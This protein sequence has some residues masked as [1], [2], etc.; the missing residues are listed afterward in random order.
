MPEGKNNFLSRELPV[1]NR[2]LV[3]PQGSEMEYA[4][5]EDWLILEEYEEGK[6]LQ[7]APRLGWSGRILTVIIVLALFA[8]GW[9]AFHF[10]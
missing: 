3:M 10:R 4:S 2:V 7:A 8:F 1:K 5:E 9:A 6:Y